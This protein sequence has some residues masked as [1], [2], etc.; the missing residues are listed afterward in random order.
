VHVPAR[1]TRS[2]TRRLLSHSGTRATDN[3]TQA[4][5]PATT[6]DLTNDTTPAFSSIAAWADYVQAHGARETSGVSSWRVVAPDVELAALALVAFVEAQH[7]EEAVNLSAMMFQGVEIGF[8]PDNDGSDMNLSSLFMPDCTF[9]V[10]VLNLLYYSLYSF[11]T[12]SGSGIGV[13]VERAVISRAINISLE[14]HHLWQ[15]T[16][17]EG[18]KCPSII[19][20][21]SDNVRLNR[22]KTHGTLCALHIFRLRQP[23]MPCSPFLLCYTIWGFDALV[24]SA[25]IEKLAPETAASLAALPLDP[26]QPLDYSLVGPLAPL[27]ATYSNIQVCIILSMYYVSQL[28]VLQPSQLPP[29]MSITQRQDLVGQVYATALLGCPPGAMLDMSKEVF[30]FHR[31][32]DVAIS[33]EI[34]SFC[35]VSN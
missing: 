31:G 4:S 13:G 6:I 5:A 12:L 18:Y 25:F 3:R 7:N 28:R 10:Y 32:F 21:G 30:Y 14:D 33:D 11:G 26:T 17:N 35:A 15:A 27:L 23:P 16:N 22:L 29:N 8:T 1:P 24:D 34:P 20:F 19:P 2:Q 9:K